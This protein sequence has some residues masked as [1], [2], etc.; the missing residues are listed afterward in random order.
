MAKRKSD[1]VEEFLSVKDIRYGIIETTDGR[2]VKI[3][4]IEPINFMLRSED[5]QYN[6]V[7]TFA[8]WL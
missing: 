7:M 2:Y 8:S 6:I 4:E 3:L 1:T 5:E